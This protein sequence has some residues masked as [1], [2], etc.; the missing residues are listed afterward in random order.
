MRKAKE[1]VGLKNVERL[2][3]AIDAWRLFHNLAVELIELHLKPGRIHEIN[4]NTK[5]TILYLV[6]GRDELLIGNEVYHLDANESIYVKKGLG[7]R[8]K[9]NTDSNALKLL[10]LIIIN[11]EPV[12]ILI[13]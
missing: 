3:V 6:P 1:V 9:K 2:F 12:I 11:I 8:W 4:T 10:V 13:S 5:D 7:R